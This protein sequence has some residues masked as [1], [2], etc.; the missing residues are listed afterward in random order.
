M[1]VIEKEIEE[2]KKLQEMWES[3]SA[4]ERQ[5]LKIYANALLDRKNLEEA[6]RT[7]G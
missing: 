3:L 4:S 2:G 1:I 7:A 6:E 5:Q